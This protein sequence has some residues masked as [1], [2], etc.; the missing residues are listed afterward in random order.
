MIVIKYRVKKPIIQMQLDDY[1]TCRAPE[2]YEM[3]VPKDYR[4]AR[5]C[6]KSWIPVQGYHHK[7]TSTITKNL[8]KKCTLDAFMPKTS[9]LVLP[10]PAYLLR[11]RSIQRFLKE[12]YARDS[13]TNR[14][15]ILVNSMKTFTGFFNH[16]FNLNDFSKLDAFFSSSNIFSH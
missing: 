5:K 8:P 3:W 10:K 14:E 6:F 4:K 1:L 15:W 7:S 13:I 11:F 9:P 2:I 12:D 16:M